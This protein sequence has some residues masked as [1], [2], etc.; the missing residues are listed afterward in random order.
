MPRGN[1]E[2]RLADL[3]AALAALRV[4][5]RSSAIASRGAEAPRAV[6]WART[7]LDPAT[8]TYP[9]AGTTPN[10]YPIIF[11]DGT[12][13]Q[14]VGQQTPTWTNRQATGKSVVHNVASGLDAYIPITSII[15][16]WNDRGRWWTDW[17]S[18]NVFHV[19]VGTTIPSGVSG[20][21]TLP[22]GR[23]VTAT[24]WGPDAINGDKAVVWRTHTD[25]AWYFIKGGSTVV[26]GPYDTQKDEIE[27][28][29]YT[30]FN[31]HTA[32]FLIKVRASYTDAVAEGSTQTVENFVN[33]GPN[34]NHPDEPYL[35]EGE[36]GA[37][38][39]AVYDTSS[40]AYRA[41]FVECPEESPVEVYVPGGDSSMAELYAAAAAETQSNTSNYA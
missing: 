34:P 36:Y 31:K 2:D 14:T 12:Y 18:P 37:Q 15:P 9:A 6:R 4:D 39:V 38:C 32:N 20:S 35:F 41:R 21:I 22:N 40:G 1:V 17:P 27:G 8:F 7:V 28:W 23:V 33:G 3:E 24:N 25:G 30:P 16:V 13:T 11:L 5:A 10:T 19:T 29:V 26:V